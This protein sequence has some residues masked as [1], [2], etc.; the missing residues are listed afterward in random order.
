M[1]LNVC[2][3]ENDDVEDMFEEIYEAQETDSIEASLVRGDK[4]KADKMPTLKFSL[5]DML[6]TVVNQ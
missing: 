3:A 5:G 2:R 4:A 6:K 1:D